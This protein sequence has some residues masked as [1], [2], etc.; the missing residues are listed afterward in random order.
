MKSPKQA[1]YEIIDI[2]NLIADPDVRGAYREFHEK[3]EE[4][5]L[6][7]PA[8]VKHHHAWPGGYAVHVWE[9]MKNLQAMI[10]G[11]QIAQA[12]NNFTREDWICASF[13]HDLDKLLYRYE[14]D[15][16]AGRPAAWSQVKDG[17]P[18]KRSLGQYDSHHRYRHGALEF[19]DGAIVMKL[20]SDHG[21]KLSE[22]ALH[23]VC[24]HHGGFSALA[25]TRHNL[26]V[27]PLG[28]L[29]HCADYVSSSIQL[30][31]S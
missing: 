6:T 1:W 25:R 11:L 15:P 9:V 30:G 29:L 24:V 12:L 17:E 2:L 8:S 19:E 7:L 3:Y 14:I 27:E 20:C 16:D 18:V 13:V 4:Q 10:H 21:L 26:D 28:V 31:R 22:Q 5:A 23:A